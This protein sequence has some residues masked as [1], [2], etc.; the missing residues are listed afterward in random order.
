M[1]RTASL[2][3]IFLD[4]DGTIIEEVGYLTSLDM[5]R[6]IPGTGAA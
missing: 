3:P 2:P 1:S 6:L 4:R 5:L